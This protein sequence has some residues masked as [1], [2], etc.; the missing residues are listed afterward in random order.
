M[1]IYRLN[2]FIKENH[3]DVLDYWV[4]R[5][6]I[7]YVRVVSRKT[8]HLYM[9]K[10]AGYNISFGEDR[11]PLMKTECFY[12]ETVEESD[13]VPE[14]L[15]K[16]YDTFLSAYPEHR[17]RFVLHQCHYLMESRDSVFRVCNMPSNGFY[18]V[19]L[20]VELEWFY[21]NLYVVNHEVDRNLSHILHKAKK[22]YEGF[23]PMYSNFVRNSD[24]D[25]ALVQTTWAYFQEQQQ[26]LEKS[27][28]FFVSVCASESSHSAEL[29]EL[30][31]IRAE[32]LSFQD[33]VRRSHQRK[34]LHDK[35]SKLR[36]LHVGTME[37]M[38]YFQSL[39][40]NLLL[41]FLFFLADI[42]LL[43]TKFHSHFIEL[44]NLVPVEHRKHKML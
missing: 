30:G 1:S 17:Y 13:G 43:L 7:R 31:N 12:L 28:Q 39:Q 9:V 21:E 41:H 18:N 44:E 25:V 29:T 35:L 19:H 11:D 26:L 37:K 34:S 33:T 4:E 6:L 22:V 32:S 36:G 10:V 27:R 5:S 20:F 40:N 16:L 23:L 15:G 24:K 42:T 38:V 8:G 3:H 2:T 14:T